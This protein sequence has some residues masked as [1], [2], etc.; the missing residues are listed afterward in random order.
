[1]ATWNV[2]TMLIPRKMQE[3]SKEMMK[4]K[5]DI[6]ALQE[7]RWQGQGRIDKPD[8]ALLYNGSEEKTGQLGTGCMVNKTMKGSLFD[9]EPQNNRICKIRLKG[10]FRNISYISSCTQER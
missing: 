8:Y 3:I 6:I 1:M 10:R 7:I 4:Y 9:F 2:R 5:I